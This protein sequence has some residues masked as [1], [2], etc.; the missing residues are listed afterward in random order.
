MSTETS[1]SIKIQT[2]GNLITTTEFQLKLFLRKSGNCPLV[3]I[4]L[5]KLLEASLE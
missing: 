1:F 4:V 2:S 3:Q 5:E